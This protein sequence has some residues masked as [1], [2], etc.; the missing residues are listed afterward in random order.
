MVKK[1]LELHLV[2]SPHRMVA[3]FVLLG[4]V[5]LIKVVEKDVIA[6][7]ERHFEA[8]NGKIPER[9]AAGGEVSGSRTF[10]CPHYEGRSR[11][12]QSYNGAAF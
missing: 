11:K 4:L 9:N 5:K 10:S 3:E 6:V 12:R 8:Q 1:Y 2:A 7:L